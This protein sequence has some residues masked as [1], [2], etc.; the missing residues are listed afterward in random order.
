MDIEAFM[1]SLHLSRASRE[2]ADQEPVSVLLGAATDSVA[3][4]VP[5]ISRDDVQFPVYVSMPPVH[6]LLEHLLSVFSIDAMGLRRDMFYLQR[7]LSF[8]LNI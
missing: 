2:D 3:V 7:Y 1:G 8:T 4:G 6:L 5:I